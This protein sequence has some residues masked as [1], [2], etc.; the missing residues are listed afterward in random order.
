MF[1]MSFPPPGR[2]RRV[3]T[4]LAVVC[5][6][7][8]VIAL[9]EPSGDD[10]ATAT[11]A[12]AR[13][14]STA[15]PSTAP[16]VSPSPRSTAPARRTPAQRLDILGRAK[17]WNLSGSS[18]SEF[19]Q[20]AC[21]MADETDSRPDLAGESV[22]QALAM[23]TASADSGKDAL[24]AGIPVLCPKWTK[25]LKASL[26]GQ[27]DR[28]ITDD[29]YDIGTEPS[30]IPPGTY[31][32]AG[33]ISDCYWERTAANGDVIDNGLVTAARRI[34]VHISASDSTFTSDNCGV[35]TPIH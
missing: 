7:T 29:T 14:P 9:G 6:S 13:P 16:E 12:S 2:Q 32:T 26:S 24:R 22:A 5:V 21:D 11:S 25:A 35:W 20:D 31:R 28:W 3:G 23:R 15:R 17:K 34:T 30:Q 33:D 27:Y 19:A 1:R 8:L 18:A 10:T 4:L